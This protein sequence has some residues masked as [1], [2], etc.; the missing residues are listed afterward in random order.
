ME[1]T[2][3]VMDMD[4][5]MTRIIQNMIILMAGMD[6]VM[7][8]L[9][10]MHMRMGHMWRL[11]LDFGL[12]CT[13]ATALRVVPP[14]LCLRLYRMTVFMFMFIFKP[15]LASVRVPFPIPFSIT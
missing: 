6:I 9:M 7:I 3:T 10:L 8:M 12:R 11:D 4:I 5:A 2:D 14:R 1:G 15:T 13:G